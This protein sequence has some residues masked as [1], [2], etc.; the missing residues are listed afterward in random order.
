M[1]FLWQL[2]VALNLDSGAMLKVTL[3]ARSA[4]GA[5]PG[6]PP[7]LSKVL[8][9]R[10]PV[11]LRHTR[12]FIAFISPS[13]AFTA[14]LRTRTYLLPRQSRSPSPPTTARPRHKQLWPRGSKHHGR[15][16]ACTRNRQ[17]PVITLPAWG[18]AFANRSAG[19]EAYTRG[20]SRVPR[21]TREAGAVA[22]RIA[23]GQ[24]RRCAQEGDQEA[25]ALARQGQGLVKF[26]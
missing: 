26:Q 13:S 10:S 9:D 11:R 5:Y 19:D 22:E 17:G 16:Q 3:V 18:E 1:Q 21:S 2:Q 25:A 7:G 12:H 8:V 14:A 23:K 6:P 20:S 4:A 15:P 24:A